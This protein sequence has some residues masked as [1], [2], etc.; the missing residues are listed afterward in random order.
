M[1]NEQIEKRFLF[2][3]EMGRF[4]KYIYNDFESY[5]FNGNEIVKMIRILKRNKYKYRGDKKYKN[6]GIAN[7]LKSNNLLI[8][9]YNSRKEYFIYSISSVLK[10]NLDDYIQSMPDYIENFKLTHWYDINL[11]K[12][13]H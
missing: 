10:C 2:D 3:L 4:K 6:N 8:Q 5:L 1:T 7:V 12:W 9:I 13:V 11:Y